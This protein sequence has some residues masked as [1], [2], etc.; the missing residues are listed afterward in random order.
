MRRCRTAAQVVCTLGPASRTVPILEEM[1]R[2][3]MN[4]ARFNF[5][6]GSH[7][8]HQVRR[9][10]AAGDGGGR[11]AAQRELA[12]AAKTAW[13]ATTAAGW[14]VLQPIGPGAAAGSAAAFVRLAVT[15]PARPTAGPPTGDAEQP[16]DGDAQHAHHVRGH[17]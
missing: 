17:A 4:V 3:G 10:M 9:V 14:R 5:S 2:S 6:H 7:E 11:G 12:A 1:L 16:A 13:V 15:A 8:Y